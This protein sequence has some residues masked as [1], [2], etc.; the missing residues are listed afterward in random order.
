MFLG[1]RENHLQ[2]DV[3]VVIPVT[4]R[5]QA[6]ADPRTKD[7]PKC[8]VAHDRFDDTNPRRIGLRPE[9]V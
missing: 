8:L 7:G 9:R 5:A 1:L 6:A 3:L 2:V 4:L